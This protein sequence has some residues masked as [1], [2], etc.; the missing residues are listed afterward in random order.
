MLRNV[1]QAARQ[2]L[3]EVAAAIAKAA[4]EVING[5]LDDRF[6]SSSTRQARGRRPQTSTRCCPT[7]YPDSRQRGG[8][9]DPCTPTTTVGMVATTFPTAMSIA[10]Y[11]TTNDLIPS[12]KHL[13]PPSIQGKEFDSIIKIGRTHCQGHAHHPRAGLLRL[14]EAG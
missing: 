14:R 10:A 1:Q 5:D 13:T 2:A 3:P 9:K 7:R 8:S 11:T 6:P 4:D 12:L